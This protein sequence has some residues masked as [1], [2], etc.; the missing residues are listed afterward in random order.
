LYPEPWTPQNK[1]LTA[2]MKLNRPFVTTELKKDI[3]AMYKELEAK[4]S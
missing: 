3:E 1:F 2:A 4:N